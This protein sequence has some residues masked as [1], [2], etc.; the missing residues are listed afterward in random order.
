MSMTEYYVH[1]IS[2]ALAA[3]ETGD[4]DV[5]E[6]ILREALAGDDVED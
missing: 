3:L 1:K 6:E 2:E 5:A 4:F